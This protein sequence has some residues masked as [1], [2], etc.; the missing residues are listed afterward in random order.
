MLHGANFAKRPTKEAAALDG[1]WD[2]PR[3]LRAVQTALY[4]HTAICRTLWPMDYTPEALGQLLVK[5]DWGGSARPDNLR[6]KMVEQL[7]DR[8]MI[9]NASR[10]VKGKPPA[11]HRRIKEVWEDI[12]DSAGAA[13][14]QSSHPS[15]ATNS[16]GSTNNASRGTKRGKNKGS[17]GGGFSGPP[18]APNRKHQ[19]GFRMNVCKV[20]SL[21][22]CHRFNDPPGCAR[23]VQGQGCKTPKGQAFA[24]NCNFLKNNGEYCLAAHPRHTVHK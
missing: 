22:V 12:A 8:V 15:T 4:S 5:S 18:P 23:E 14:G 21:Y 7:F 13:P 16:A 9:E 17:G 3:K 24:H 19:D 11:D 1:D 20:G 10:A 2:A 6:A